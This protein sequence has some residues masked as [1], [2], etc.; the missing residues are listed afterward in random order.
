[1]FRQFANVRQ[2]QQSRMF[3]GVFERRVA[4]HDVSDSHLKAQASRDGS[5]IAGTDCSNVHHMF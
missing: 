4:S 3:G 2:R 5:K 1:M